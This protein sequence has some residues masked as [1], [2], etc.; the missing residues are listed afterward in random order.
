[1]GGRVI[2]A[3]SLRSVVQG[4]LRSGEAGAPHAYVVIAP[5]AGHDPVQT[6]KRGSLGRDERR[7][8]S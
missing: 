5:C 8:R 2:G 6:G 7:S 4:K 3:S 1:V